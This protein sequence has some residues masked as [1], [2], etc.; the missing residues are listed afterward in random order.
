LV[1][2]AKYSVIYITSDIKED[3]TSTASNNRSRNTSKHHSIDQHRNIPTLQEVAR[4]VARLEKME[5]DEK[6]YIAYEMIALLFF[7]AL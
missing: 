3:D 6:Q 7:L 4:K 1:G 5:L 2:G